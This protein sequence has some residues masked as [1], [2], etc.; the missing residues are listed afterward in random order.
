MAAK[1]VAA[2]YYL[3][4]FSNKTIFFTRKYIVFGFREEPVLPC[5]R[6]NFRKFYF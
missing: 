2:I 5:L 3:E 6:Q 1:I 4:G